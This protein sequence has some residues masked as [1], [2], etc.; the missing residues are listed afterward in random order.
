VTLAAIA[1]LGI[2]ARRVYII[3]TSIAISLVGLSAALLIP[4]QYTFPNVGHTFV[5]RRSSPS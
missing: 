1:L 3:S 2:E 5:S 4:Y